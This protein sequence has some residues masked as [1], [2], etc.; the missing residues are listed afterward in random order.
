VL[1][2]GQLPLP[3]KTLKTAIS[4]ESILLIC[5]KRDSIEMLQNAS[6]CGQK[7]TA[8]AYKAK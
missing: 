7:C 3:E 6:L 4:P 5:A 8:R 2:G 1:C